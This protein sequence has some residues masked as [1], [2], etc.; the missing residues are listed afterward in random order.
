MSETD[1]NPATLSKAAVQAMV[2]RWVKD[3][4]MNAEQI[5]MAVCTLHDY[6]ASLEARLAE[7]ES[8]SRH[9]VTIALDGRGLADAI[10]TARLPPQ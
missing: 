6:C 5:L 4:G 3:H 10:A 8:G 2:D 9:R 1:K 7:L